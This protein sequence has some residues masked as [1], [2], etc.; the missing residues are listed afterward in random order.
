MHQ[1]Y[2]ELESNFALFDYFRCA[3]VDYAVITLCFDLDFAYNET[4]IPIAIILMY[5][6]FLDYCMGLDIRIAKATWACGLTYWFL[7]RFIMMQK[8]LG[9]WYKSIKCLKNCIEWYTLLWYWCV[10][11]MSSTIHNSDRPFSQDQLYLQSNC[12]L[13]VII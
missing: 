4:N 10:G 7:I 13:Y 5:I 1:S 11:L 8:Y 12:N 2:T 3:R 6:F 9:W